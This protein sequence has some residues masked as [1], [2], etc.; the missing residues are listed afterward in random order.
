MDKRSDAL[1]VDE[2]V[3]ALPVGRYQIA[4]FVVCFLIALMD[5]ANIQAMGLVAPVLANDLKLDPSRLGHIFSASE[6]GFMLGALFFGP[7]ADRFG[8]KQLLIAG[9]VLFGASTLLT[10]TATS[11]SELL[12]FRLVTG[13]GLGGAAPCF[14]SLCSEYFAERHEAR[15]TTLLWA[16]IPAGAAVGGVAASWLLPA[17]GWQSVFVLAGAIPLVLALLV[18]LV[19]P[20]SLRYLVV[21]GN[22]EARIRSILNRLG[23]LREGLDQAIFATH[24]RKIE[25]GSIKALFSGDRASFTILLWSAFFLNFF[26]LIAVLAWTSTL[27]RSVG[28]SV[29]D[30]AIVMAVNNIGGMIGVACAGSLMERFGS[31]R[32]LAGALVVGAVAV[33]LTGIAAPGLLPVIVLALMVGL[34]VGG[35]TSGLIALAVTHYPTAVRSTGVGWGLAAGRLGGASGPVFTGALVASGVEVS[36]VFLALGVPVLITSGILLVMRRLSSRKVA[37]GQ[38]E[39]LARSP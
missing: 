20:E 21:V 38:I 32:C 1:K 35:G 4:I 15:V 33:A 19:L 13:F 22:K 10:V 16:A 26:C 28:V 37:V 9:T 36:T 3:D 27:L 24:E 2:L 5:G 29:E 25:A 39:G 31:F 18:A 12:A 11:Y 14:V 17:F 30:A 34:F 23:V 6:V 7:L 8:R